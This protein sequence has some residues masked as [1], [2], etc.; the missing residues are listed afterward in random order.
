MATNKKSN[1][2]T[3][4]LQ[5]LYTQLQL[6]ENQIKDAEE[7]IAAVEQQKNEF[8]AISSG[9][10]ELSKQKTGINSY[11]TLGVG[12][13]AKAKI[14]DTNSFLVNVGNDTFVEKNSEDLKKSLEA[15][16]KKIDSVL[17]NLRSNHQILI[18][19]IQMLQTH[20]QDTVEGK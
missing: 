3:Q 6:L 10:S 9:L 4:K 17:S 16:S 13:F 5:Q 20:M 15:Q 8:S 14:M 1:E 11:A 19:Q 7:Q 12:I 18:S 2:D